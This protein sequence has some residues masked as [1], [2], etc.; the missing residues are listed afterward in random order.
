MTWMRQG[1]TLGLEARTPGL[2]LA[3]VSLWASTFTSVLCSASFT[4]KGTC[5]ESTRFWA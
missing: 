5:S 4:D 3:D 2:L 1:H